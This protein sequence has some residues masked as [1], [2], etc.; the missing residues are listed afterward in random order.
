MWAKIMEHAKEYRKTHPYDP[1]NPESR[2][3][4]EE[5]YGENRLPSRRSQ[6]SLRQGPPSRRAELRRHLRLR[7]GVGARFAIAVQGQRLCPDRHHPSGI[8]GRLFALPPPLS[9]GGQA[10]DV[11]EAFGCGVVELVSAVVGGQAVVIQGVVGPSGPPQRRNP[12]A[13]GRGCLPTRAAACCPRMHPSPD[14]APCTTSR[15]RP[16][17]RIP[18]RCVP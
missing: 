16:V 18:G 12:C 3:W 2:V 6:P 15:Y 11:D 1:D 7:A 8:S 10:V 17:P 4:Q 5:L 9:S 13:G 14:G